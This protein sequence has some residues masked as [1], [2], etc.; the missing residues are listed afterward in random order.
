MD[1]CPDCTNELTYL[2]DDPVRKI[3]RVFRI[4]VSCMIVCHIEITRPKSVRETKK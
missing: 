1:E 2:Y 4:C 3:V